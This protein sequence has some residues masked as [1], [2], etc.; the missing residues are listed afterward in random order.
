MARHRPEDALTAI[1]EVVRQSAEGVRRSE[2]AMALRE[3]PQRTLQS[4]L[5]SLVEDGRIT[6]EDKGPAS[7]YRFQSTAEQPE[8]TVAVKPQVE[9]EKT[10]ELSIPLSTESKKIRTYLRQPFEARKA[11]GY[12]RRFLDN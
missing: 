11:V 6:Q 2:I 5:K 10:T 8:N 12:D 1:V 3:I 7:R 9:E 4:W